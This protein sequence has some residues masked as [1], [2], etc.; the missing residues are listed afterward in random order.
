MWKVGVLQ[1]RDSEC[2]SLENRV[3]HAILANDQILLT[4]ISQ[5]QAKRFGARWLDARA[6]WSLPAARWN[7]A[8]I[9]DAGIDL[10][11]LRDRLVTPYAAID[12]ERLYPYQREAAGRLVAAP[13][14]I[15]VTLSPGLGKTAVAIAAADRVVPDDRIV[16]VAPAS[17]LR[18]WERE[19]AKWAVVSGEVY[20]IQGK[21]D[22]DAAHC[23]RWIIVSWDKAARELESWGKGWPLWILD[24]SVLTK[25]RQSKRFKAMNKLRGQVQ[26]MWL[27]SGSPTTRYADD[28]WA[29]LHL[30]W[31]TAFLVLAL[32]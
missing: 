20:I 23:A 21:V 3:S 16:V 26:R 19:I 17:L 31:P 22:F 32:R 8:A 29:Q 15:L 10:P 27:L 4:G 28:L 2:S 12:D 24:E 30:L 9:V 18:T 13:H 25:S 7:A 11:D 5:A 14:G 6:A 1:P